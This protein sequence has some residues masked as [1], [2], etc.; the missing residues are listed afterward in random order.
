MEV[1]QHRQLVT[2]PRIPDVL[3]STAQ[4]RYT[5]YN[6]L[7]GSSGAVES[8]LVN[9]NL[10]QN[11]SST[12]QEFYIAAEENV[13]IKI[14]R[15]VITVADSAVAHNNFGAVSALTN[16]F[17]LQVFE[18]GVL[19]NLING[20]KTGGELIIQAG[21]FSPYGDGATSFEL[22]NWSGNSDAQ[23]VVID[24]GA[25]VPGGIRIARKT[26]DRIVAT[27]QDN[28]TGLVEFT[29]RVMGHRHHE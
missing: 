27:V 6:A 24:V 17:T 25:L 22:S 9:A 18:R 15:V 13:D 1:G 21:G 8:G 2:S 19:T 26:E 28:L 29:V 14:M 4:N 16:G 7:L 11:G 20:A 3:P 10:N 12:A 5:M 23:T